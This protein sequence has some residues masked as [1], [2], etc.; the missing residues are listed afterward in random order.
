M[1]R[2]GDNNGALKEFREATRLYPKSAQNFTWLGIAENQLGQF[3]PAAKDFQSALE[4]DPT[5]LSAHYNFAHTLVELGN[6]RGAVRE[7]RAV[8]KKNPALLDVQFNLAVLLQKTEQY[9]EAAKYFEAVREKRP[10]DT[11][12]TGRLADCYF[13]TSRTKQAQELAA[14]LAGST[15][16]PD[17]E[18][19]LASDLIENG[20]YS[21]AISL[22]STAETAAGGP[23]T[24]LLLARAYLGSGQV[25]RAVELLQTLKSSNPSS[26]VDY[27]LGLAYL[28]IQKPDIAVES[29]RNAVAGDA[30]N[31]DARYHL[32]VLL[33]Q[34]SDSSIQQQGAAE[35]EASIRIAPDQGASYEAL[36]K[37]LLQTG[38]ADAALNLLQKAGH[39][40][41]LSAQATL[42]L[43]ISEAAVHGSEA[44]QTIVEKAIALDPQLAL[45]H[46]ILGFCYFRAAD[47]SRA[48]DAYAEALKL[49]PGN[50]LFAYDAAL[51][52][53][54]QSKIAAAIPL[55]ETAVRSN[56]A[57]SA[58]HYLL[59]KLYS[60][61]NRGK[62]AI[63]ELEKAVQLNPTVENPYYLLARTYMQTG[64]M[65]KAQE[66]STKFEQLKQAQNK[67]AGLGPPASET[68]DGLTP[69]L[70]LTTPQATSAPGKAEKAP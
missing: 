48:Y 22:L 23:T 70:T 42:L 11:A 32:G 65:Q 2:A 56:P 46:N 4:L 38:H 16:E 10:A 69:S 20:S 31:S 14:G 30:R 18:V 24:K 60:K 64:D 41:T 49:E 54:R 66:W 21:Q 6:L 26:E 53:E 15:V 35:L 25:D 39:V 13:H 19:L 27:L 1:L 3:R 44:A 36:A 47:Y 43:G 33:L 45:A 50:G 5:L 63:P 12:V 17:A 58:N 59:G 67:Q 29:F 57:R 40:V 37:W 7:L 62:D 8:L 55:A 61:A 9:A 68:A 52:L 51:A 34:N 28:S